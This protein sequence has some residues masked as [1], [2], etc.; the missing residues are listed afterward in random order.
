MN[1]DLLF[2][3]WGG[4]YYMHASHKI[5]K[6]YMMINLSSILTVLM[7]LFKLLKDDDI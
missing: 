7:S 1:K 3:F 2:F 6:K 4:G 5:Y